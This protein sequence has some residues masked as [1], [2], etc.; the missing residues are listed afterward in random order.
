ML[1]LKLITAPCRLR[2]NY[3]YHVF[4]IKYKITNHKC[5]SVMRISGVFSHAS[6]TSIRKFFDT[7][8][9]FLQVKKLDRRERRL[10]GLRFF[11][12]NM[13]CID[14]HFSESYFEC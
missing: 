12:D 10:N 3:R 4:F 11:S 13:L 6:S 5:I 2:G 9:I 8:I 7:E 14:L 1:S